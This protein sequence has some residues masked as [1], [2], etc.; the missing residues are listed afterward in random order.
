MAFLS[1]FDELKGKAEGLAHKAG[2]FAAENSEKVANGI[3]KAG[4]FV[5]EKTGGKY[6]DK[7]DSVQDGARNLLNK[8]KGDNTP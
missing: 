2:Q 8:L 5:D 7:V 4:N 6:A 1:G 3:D